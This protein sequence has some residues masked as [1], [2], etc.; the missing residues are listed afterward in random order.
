MN[1][2][3]NICKNKSYRMTNLAKKIDEINKNLAAQLPAD[4]IEV[5]SQSIQELKSSKIEEN[6]TQVGNK[7]PN[8]SLK[9][10][11]NQIIHLNELLKKGKVIVA[12]FRGSWCPYCNV[13]LKALQDHMEFFKEKNIS[14]VAIAP[15]SESYNKEL[16]VNHMLRYDILTDQDNTLAKQ[17]GISF[18]LPNYALTTYEKLGIKL[19]K[20]NKN[21][22]KELPIP[23]VYIID[24]N[25]NITYQF[26]D[27]NYMNR[28]NIQDLIDQL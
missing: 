1:L 23:A 15:Q 24:T 14:L 13:E 12:F 2:L 5:F 18:E 6:S 27:S 11:S 4:I 22:H 21:D 8:F 17:L 25:Y 3:L 9:N 28:V 19:S 26:V 20:Y 10:T 16:E 7:F